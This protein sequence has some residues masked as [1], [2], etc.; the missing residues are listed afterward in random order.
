MAFIDDKI[1]GEEE[2]DDDALSKVDFD[3][4]VRGGVTPPRVLLLTVIAGEDVVVRGGVVGDGTPN[5]V[6]EVLVKVVVIP[7]GIVVTMM[8]KVVEVMR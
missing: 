6:V 1:V 5:T 4:L 3:K 7:P 2:S 8:T